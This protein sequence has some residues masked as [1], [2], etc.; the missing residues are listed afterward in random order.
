[1]SMMFRVACLLAVF[2]VPPVQATITVP[3]IISDHMV[4]QRESTVPIWGKANPGEAVTVTLNDEAVTTEAD[5]D[6]KWRVDLPTGAAG[7]PFTLTITGE[8]D[9]ALVIKDVLLGE[10]WLCS[11]QS[12]ME[13]PVSLVDNAEEEMAAADTP[14]IRHMKI[15]H[16]LSTVPLHDQDRVWEIAAP[17]TI[18]RFSGVSYFFAKRLQAELDVPIGLLNIYWGGTRIEPWTPIEG[19]AMIDSLEPIYQR[20]LMQDPTSEVHQ[21]A[22]GDY[23][24]SIES[25][26]TQAK[27]A[28][29]KSIEP[30]P[31]MPQKLQPFTTRHDPTVLFNGMLS[32]AIPYRVRGA[33][34][35]QGEGNHLEDDYVDKTLALVRG[36][37]KVWQADM[38][39]YYV[40]IAPYRYG[41]EQPTILARFWEQQAR[42]EDELDDAYMVVINDVANLKDIHPRNK[43]AVGKRLAGLALA[44]TYGRDDIVHTGPRFKSLKQE[45]DMLRVVF[46]HVGGGLTTRDGKAPDWFQ[47]VGSDSAWT[48]AEAVIDGD[49]VLLKADNVKQ[50]VAVRFAFHKLAEPNL[51]NAEGLPAAPFRAGDEPDT[52]PL[53]RDITEDDEYELVYDLD[54]HRLG[55]TINYDVDNAAEI[56]QPFDRVAYFLEL[57]QPDGSH[58]WVY[59]SMDAFT[60][61]IT[62]VGVP[63]LASGAHFQQPVSNLYIASNLDRLPITKGVEGNI[64]FWPNNYDKRNTAGVPDATNARYDFGDGPDDKA[65]DGYGSMQVHFTEAKITLF[66]INHWSDATPDLGIGNSTGESDDWTFAANA[67]DYEV[68]RLRV[69]VRLKK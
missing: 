23:L 38:P 54:L 49:S 15:L 28:T 20:V 42:I 43:Q 53:L 30:P 59:V 27:A 57:K 50:P 18:G 39:Y 9:E 31:E 35:Y 45:G 69:F 8:G 55:K 36:W 41:L 17:D 6:G 58:E 61:D 40:Q 5:A 1:M 7:G 67:D 48:D 33:L 16:N 47:I 22:M 56:D 4:L 51:M 14:L 10:V 21:A 13:W 25:W 3:N 52:P 2:F 34:W 44:H 19:L 62:K 63:T 60:D 66:A 11:G 32:P 46:D 68:K 37:R 24:Q 64:E 12:N 26:L 29:G 65:P